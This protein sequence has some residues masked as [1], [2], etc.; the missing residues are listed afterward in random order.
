MLWRGQKVVGIQ[1]ED[2]TE[3]GLKYSMMRKVG[4][5]ECKGSGSSA[6]LHLENVGIKWPIFD[7]TV[8]PESR[9]MN[10]KEMRL[11]DV[12]KMVIVWSR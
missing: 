5:M 4:G 9:Y 2:V 3:N 10:W 11:D 12:H 6:R 7:V 8:S 1:I